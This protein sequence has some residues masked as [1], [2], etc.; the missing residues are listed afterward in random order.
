MNNPVSHRRHPQNAPALRLLRY[1]YLP[2]L[3][4]DLQKKE[5]DGVMDSIKRK[6]AEMTNSIFTDYSTVVGHVQAELAKFQRLANAT[7]NARNPLNANLSS[8]S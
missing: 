4:F 7:I 2:E 1:C 5:I 3:G 8:S 6:N